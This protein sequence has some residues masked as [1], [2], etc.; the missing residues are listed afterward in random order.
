VCGIA[1]FVDFA[2]GDARRLGALAQAMADRMRHRGPD[3]GAAFVDAESGFATGHRRLSIIDLSETGA[4]P[5]RSQCGRLVLSYNGE[6]YNAAELR[7]AL[8][9]VG[10]SF[11]GTSDTEVILEACAHWGVANAVPRLI[12]MFAFALW[13]ARARTLFLVRDRLGIKP[14]YWCKQGRLF[15]FAS[16]LKGL[17]AHPAFERALD[18]DAIAAYLRFGYI[19]AP[20]SV[21]RGVHKLKP[22]TILELNEKDGVRITPYWTL[23]EVVR[24]AQAHPFAGGDEEAEEELATLLADA[25]ARRMIADVPLGAFLSGGID[26]STVV[27]L[28]QQASARPVRTFSIGFREPGFNE[29]S[30]ARAIAAHLGTAHE[31]LFVTPDEARAVIPLLPEMYDEP[32]ADASQI[33][34]YLVSKLARTQVKVALSGDG[35][36]EVFCGYARYLEA[37]RFVRGR[38]ALP[39]P[40]RRRA[41]QML[42]ALPSA[43]YD[44]AAEAVP[45]SLRP[46]RLGQRVHRGAELLTEDEDALYLSVRSLWAEPHA[47]VPGARAPCGL[48]DGRAA[49][50]LVPAFL[51]RMQYVDS[52]TYLPDDILVKVDRAAMA[53][54]L[55]TR[56]PMLDHRLV[57][58][59]WRVPVGH[60]TDGRSGKLLLR[61]VLHRYVPPQLVERPKM[62]FGVPIDAWLRGPLRDW[63]EHLLDPARLARDGFFNAAPVTAMWRSHLDGRRQWQYPL[64]VVLMF[65][66]WLDDTHAR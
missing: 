54:S 11:R 34:T 39:G 40:V 19:P 1:G 30:H 18:R 45:Q 7:A 21:Y 48:H 49:R 36:D 63:A 8:K 53:I 56:V 35:G 14:L 2:P 5:M 46:E 51:A 66:A 60:K 6:A 55:E 26:S 23:E 42:R 28:M 31:E 47:L 20:H 12:G 17:C 3:A 52:L 44:A 37:L 10:K 25:V 50:A 59:A 41:A 33:P 65:Q 24:E 27:A 57:E 22:G 15:L 32:L 64:W 38:R 61:S 62:G 43:L 16:E 58:F 9:S 29:A 13:D 4:Q